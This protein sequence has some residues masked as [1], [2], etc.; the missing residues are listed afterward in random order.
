MQR[1]RMLKQEQYLQKQLELEI[2]ANEQ[3]KKQPLQDNV[4]E[5]QQ[6]LGKIS[7][8]EVGVRPSDDAS[9]AAVDVKMKGKSG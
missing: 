7:E 1:N 5:I 8:D 3:L 9:A 4:P 2:Q 6:Q